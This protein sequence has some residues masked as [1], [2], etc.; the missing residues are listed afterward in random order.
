METVANS[1]LD[2]FIDNVAKSLEPAAFAEFREPE[3]ICLRR[4]MEKCG[5]TQY[6]VLKGPASG[7]RASGA[8]VRDLCGHDFYS[9]P[10][11]WRVIGYGN[12]PFLNVLCDGTRVKL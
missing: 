9:H 2:H 12:V 11:D 7:E 4:S 10:A 6:P 8:C 5:L 3:R 1:T